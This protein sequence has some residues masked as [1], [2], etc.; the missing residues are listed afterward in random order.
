MENDV[1]TKPFGANHFTFFWDTDVAEHFLREK[2]GFLMVCDLNMRKHADSH[3]LNI[4]WITMD[5]VIYFLRNYLDLKKLGSFGLMNSGSEGSEIRE[6]CPET[7]G[8]TKKIGTG[9]ISKLRHFLLC[10]V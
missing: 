8:E 10:G 3:V 2:L 1:Q 7:K 5:C 4:R 9:K 6:I